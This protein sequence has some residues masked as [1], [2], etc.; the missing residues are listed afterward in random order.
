MEHRHFGGQG[1]LGRVTALGPKR[2]CFRVA[3]DM[4]VA[5]AGVQRDRKIH[6]GRGLMAA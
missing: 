5:V 4:G 3:K 1:C 2:E 6:G